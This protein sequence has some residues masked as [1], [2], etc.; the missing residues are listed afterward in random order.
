[1]ALLI[2]L[3]IF[4][5]LL[6]V[7]FEFSSSVREEAAA[8]HR[9]ADE[10]QG[11]YMAL[12]GFERGVY[13]L[14]QQ[15]AGRDALAD[16]KRADIFDG[17]WQEEALGGGTFRVRWIDEGGKIN[18]NRANEE[19]LRRVFS[20]LGIEE[21]KKTILID[22]I[23]DWRDADDLHRTSGAENEY[24]GSLTPPYTAKNGP[25]DTV[26]ELLWVRGASTELFYGYGTA[27]GN[28]AET[29]QRLGLREIFTVDSPVD[30]VN[31]R[32][33]SAEVIHA[34][35]GMPLEKSRR[36]ADE[37][38]KLS[39]KTLADLLPLLGI[40]AGDAALQQFVFA[41]PTVVSVEA[42]GRPADSSVSRRVKGVVRASGG[43]REFEL[44]RWIDRDIGL[45]AP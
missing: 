16:H 39:E 12:A 4:V 22:S 26:E 8:A 31:L 19:T 41:N 28:R 29:G 20:N 5:F 34:L 1:A 18:I 25:F 6:V 38:K 15:A 40:G 42:E 36:F 9:Y 43:G 35:T 7:A 27:H 30:R 44:V 13:E 33:A 23:M 14:L 32:T 17:S 10:T 3:W 45:E 2:V 11:Y 21:P 37:R 24:Y